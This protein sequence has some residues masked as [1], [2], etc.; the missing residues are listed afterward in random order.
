M[1]VLI[2]CPSCS[3]LK[4]MME[5]SKG[6]IDL[7]AAESTEHG[8]ALLQTEDIDLVF[9]HLKLM[10]RDT[11]QTVRDI[12]EAYPDIRMVAAV[13]NHFSEV[14]SFLEEMN[15]SEILQSPEN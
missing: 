13:D 10:D 8:I 15:F 6:T 7:V 3:S 14:V 11:M 4:K 2:I 5:H 9:V 1:K 12:R